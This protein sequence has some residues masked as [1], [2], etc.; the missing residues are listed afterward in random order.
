MEIHYDASTPHGLIAAPTDQSTGTNWGCN[1]ILLTYTNASNIFDG[2]TNTAN[3]VAECS[4]TGSAADLCANLSI[5]IYS[6]WYLPNLAE[7]RLVNASSALI[8]GFTDAS[9]YWTS[10]QNSQYS[11]SKIRWNSNRTGGNYKTA[12]NNVRAIRSF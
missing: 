1:T 9:N 4:D 12:G 11:A 5:G 7:L 3:I 10:N 6:D 2:A 8:G